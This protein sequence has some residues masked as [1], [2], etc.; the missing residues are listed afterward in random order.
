MNT[1]QKT[2][3]VIF[4]MALSTIFANCQKDQV[5]IHEFKICQGSSN[6]RLLKSASEE[7]NEISESKESDNSEKK[8]GKGSQI[9]LPLT[10][11]LNLHYDT[12]LYFG[13]NK[14]PFKLIID[15]GSTALWIPDVD[16]INCKQNNL[17]KLY[18][19]D[20]S[21]TCHSQNKDDMINIEYGVGSVDGYVVKEN[22]YLS[23]K[24]Q[25]GFEYEFL[26]VK[27]VT[28]FKVLQIQGIIGLGR[29][30]SSEFNHQTILGSMKKK[31]VIDQRVFSLFL[32]DSSCLGNSVLVFGGYNEDYT[33]G[34]ISYIS[35]NTNEMWSVEISSAALALGTQS[36]SSN[37]KENKRSKLQ[38]STD[39][40]IIDSGTTK[41]V[42]PKP[43]LSAFMDLLKQDFGI[44]CELEK[45]SASAEIFTLVCAE[46]DYQKYPSF[47]FTLGSSPAEQKEFELTGEEYIESCF[48]HLQVRKCAL[49]FQYVETEYILLGDTFLRKYYTIFDMDN[50]RI[51]FALAKV[52]QPKPFYETPIFSAYLGLAVTIGILLFFLLI[53]KI[54]SI[55]QERNFERL[56]S[57]KAQADSPPNTTG[58]DDLHSHQRP[59]HIEIQQGND[60][61]I[62]DPNDISEEISQD[63]ISD[64]DQSQNKNQQSYRLPV[65][66]KD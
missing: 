64:I 18:N 56:H 10:N 35:V 62:E 20:K 59:G 9:L 37:Q 53:C 24:D 33:Q 25:T 4:L 19:C 1:N 61:S 45:R 38:F 6:Q 44:V 2:I 32:S 63:D 41:I 54:R 28:N 27:N 31:G 50:Q 11:M 43:D 14:Q 39:T 29:E 52:I 46:S 7:N 21:S 13:K 36:D 3:A 65:Q 26:L 66:K 57:V 48:Y 15:T 17:W 51:G 58:P 49:R 30:E 40:V 8:E 55:W 16:C 5:K 42:L 47:L 23:D 22:I 12:E 60:Q 34:P